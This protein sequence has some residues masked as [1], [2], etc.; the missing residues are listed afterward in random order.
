MEYAVTKSYY[1]IYNTLTAPCEKSKIISFAFSILK[2]IV[3]PS[4]QSRF[5]V[6]LIFCI[7][8]VLPS[9]AFGWL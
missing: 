1:K 8:F 5:P 9:S 7:A 6:K 4:S 3:A 2:N